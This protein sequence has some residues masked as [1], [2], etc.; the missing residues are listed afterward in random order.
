MKNIQAAEAL[1]KLESYIESFRVN[2][3][4]DHQVQDV[5]DITFGEEDVFVALDLGSEVYTLSYRTDNCYKT[6]V[7]VDEELIEIEF[8]ETRDLNRFFRRLGLDEIV[9]NTLMI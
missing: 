3:L 5:F 7:I 4:P 8:D 2:F 6:F 1:L 9:R